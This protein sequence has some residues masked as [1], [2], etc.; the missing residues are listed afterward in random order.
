METVIDWVV[1]A[2]D[3]VFP[4]EA[5]EVN[6]TEP[7]IQKVVGPLVTITGTPGEGFTVTVVGADAATHPE[8]FPTVTE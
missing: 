5:E 4:V 8:P 1:S 7:P 3:Q 2:V 6:V